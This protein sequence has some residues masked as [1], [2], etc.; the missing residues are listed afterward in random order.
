MEE[1]VTLCKVK[2]MK[3]FTPGRYGV[4]GVT[5]PC[6]IKLLVWWVFLCMELGWGVPFSFPLKGLTWLSPS[7][8]LKTVSLVLAWDL[9]KSPPHPLFPELLS[10]IGVGVEC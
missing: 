10:G 1:R 2:N 3:L 7:D 5:C 4:T 9:A 6:S 8:N